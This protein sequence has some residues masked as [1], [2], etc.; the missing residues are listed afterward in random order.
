MVLTSTPNALGGVP[1][2]TGRGIITL[3]EARRRLGDEET[4]SAE[5]EFYQLTDGTKSMSFEVFHS[6]F[7]GSVLP[8]SPP[9]LARALYRA[10]DMVVDEAISVEEFICGL[11]ILRM[12]TPEERLRLVFNAY[13]GDNDGILQKKDLLLFAKLCLDKQSLQDELR[14][15]D[16]TMDFRQFYEWCTQHGNVAVISWV[17]EFEKLLHQKGLRPHHHHLVNNAEKEIDC[18]G[19]SVSF[20]QELE[21]AHTYLKERNNFGVVDEETL[22]EALPSIPL[23]LR[24]YLFRTLDRDRSGTVSFAE[25]LT[26]VAACCNGPPEEKL[27][28]CFK[29]FDING[30]NRLSKNEFRNMLSTLLSVEAINSSR[31]GGISDDYLEQLEGVTEAAFAGGRTSI[32]VDELLALPEYLE[33]G[34]QFIQSMWQLAFMDLRIKPGTPKD[35]RRLVEQLNSPPYHPMSPGKVGTVWYLVDHRWWSKWWE[36]TEPLRDGEGWAGVR[37]L[38]QLDN[39]PLL[40]STGH[41]RQ[42]ID[43]SGKEDGGKDYEAITPRAWEALVLWYN[44]GFPGNAIARKVIQDGPRRELELHPPR[45]QFIA[46]TPSNL[47]ASPASKKE[48]VFSRMDS[49]HTVL[50]TAARHFEIPLDRACLWEQHDDVWKRPTRL[51]ATLAELDLADGNLFLVGDVDD[52]KRVVFKNCVGEEIDFRVSFDHGA[53][54]FKNGSLLGVAMEVEVVVPSAPAQSPSSPKPK[55]GNPPQLKLNLHSSAMGSIT[56][57]STADDGR[58]KA[59]TSSPQ[60][61]HLPAVPSKVLSDLAMLLDA[62]GV[63]HNLGDSL[64]TNDF[65]RHASS[66]VTPLEGPPDTLPPGTRI[67]CLIPDKSGKTVQTRATLLRMEFDKAVVV[68]TKKETCITIAK[69]AIVR[70]LRSRECEASS[71]G[72]VGLQNLT[73]T[74]YMNATFQV[75][76]HTRL[77]R[78]YFLSGEY[79]YDLNTKSK[80]GMGGKLAV[81]FAEL[82]E[83]LWTT[84]KPKLAPWGFRRQM[85][86]YRSD[87][88]TNHQQDVN[89]FLLSL[90][91]G[92]G[93][94]LNRVTVKKA[95]SEPAEDTTKSDMDLATQSWCDHTARENSIFTA[96]F[97]GQMKSTFKCT[98]CSTARRRIDTT[99]PPLSLPLPQ[100]NQMYVHIAL[101][102]PTEP[103]TLMT[104]PLVPKATVSDM[105]QKVTEEI[106]VPGLVASNLITFELVANGTHIDLPVWRSKEHVAKRLQRMRATGPVH[107][108]EARNF[109]LGQRQLVQAVNRKLTRGD[110]MFSTPY[111]PQLFGTPLMLCLRKGSTGRELYNAVWDQ[112]RAFVPD[113]QHKEGGKLPFVISRVTVDGQTCADC[114]WLRGCIGCKI[115]NGHQPHEVVHGDT[116]GIDWDISIFEAEYKE[117]IATYQ[118]EHRSVQEYKNKQES[119]NSTLYCCIDEYYITKSPVDLECKKCKRTTQH[120]H[121]MRLWACPPLLIIQ[122]KR[123]EWTAGGGQ[124][125]RTLVHFPIDGLDLRR[126]LATPVGDVVNTPYGDN[127]LLSREHTQYTLTGVI[128]HEGSGTAWGHYTALVRNAGRWWLMNDSM[129]SPCDESKVVSDKAYLLFYTRTDIAEKSLESVWPRLPESKPADKEAVKTSKWKR[130]PPP[131]GKG[132]K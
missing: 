126:Y 28:F 128:N 19:M 74:C 80:W 42:N 8:N 45:L 33:L 48:L 70:V 127:E 15:H 41:L 53:E 34:V 59:D 62:S 109:H 120:H 100:H 24:S 61:I 18:N 14:E 52:E 82:L 46:G 64:D 118:E 130:D 85:G 40:D 49:L 56:H 111:K 123:F 112:V 23:N 10:F 11:A 107:I 57:R 84:D 43:W 92:L 38:P 21:R 4:A 60:Y 72:R 36:S 13:D 103:V 71:F 12:G 67:D 110:K 77:L 101:H 78:E 114:G 22:S 119:E 69:D 116:V 73:N 58:G 37:C 99:M 91:E 75:M 108:F 132:R 16:D 124:K 87:F 6:C 115:D 65:V 39:S 29:L 7:V 35:E 131:A 113:F 9:P 26:A 97:C 95:S 66:M 122:L 96:L 79:Q 98:S 30:D 1:L 68:P 88:A 47:P 55:F 27:S 54:V 50:D 117:A 129:V 51:D 89:D 31:A 125:L 121:T 81:G 106:D 20:V 94:D 105:V 102:R 104:L 90:L 83:R 86:S 25:F 17:F 44:G 32:G 5:E 76:S 93:E 2:R 3:E 63:T